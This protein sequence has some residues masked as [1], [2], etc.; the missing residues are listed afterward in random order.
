MAILIGILLYVVC[1]LFF[2]ALTRANAREETESL[3]VPKRAEGRYEPAPA[4]GA[5]HAR[6]AQ[7]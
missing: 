7:L 2:C 1:V 4:G 3:V 5:V 6:E